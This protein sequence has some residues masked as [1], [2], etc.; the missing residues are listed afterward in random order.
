MWLLVAA[1]GLFLTSLFRV[2]IVTHYVLHNWNIVADFR[3]WVT[4]ID[5]FTFDAE[6]VFILSGAEGFLE[7]YRTTVQGFPIIQAL[8]EPL[9]IVLAC[10]AMV[11][12][13][14]AKNKSER[15]TYGNV[16]VGEK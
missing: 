8:F 11:M 9:G 6:G 4:W 3:R 2:I 7:G 5:E 14:R 12:W 13:W 10:A 16:V 1:G 15:V